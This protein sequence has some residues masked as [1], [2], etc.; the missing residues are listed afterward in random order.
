MN[1]IKRV[2]T[3]NRK[4][5]GGFRRLCILFVFLPFWALNAGGRTVRTAI[6]PPKPLPVHESEASFEIPDIPAELPS[7][8]A[9]SRA[10]TVFRSI[11]KAYPDRIGEIE[12][13]DGDWTIQ[14]YGEIFYY[15]EGRLLPASLRDRQ[16]EYSPQPFYNYQ[17]ELPPWQ[18]P[19]P[20][21][22]AR[23]KEQETL[24]QARPSKR[25]S[26]F[27]DA[28]WRTRNRDESWEHIKQIR[29]L[30]HTV[31]V[32]YSI[33]VDLSL[34]EE[35]ILR[36]AKTNT[37]VSRWIN[38]I[39]SV[40]AWNWRNIASS[41]SRS[42]HAYG[43]AIDILPKS[44][45]GLETYWLWTA[46]HTPE[47]WAVPYT[48]RFH[49]PDEVIAIFESFGFTWGGK[50]RYYDTMHFEYRPEILVLSGIER[51]DLKSLR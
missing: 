18:S 49:P 11:A 31:Q 19:T 8:Q 51:K 5:L 1:L 13:W 34:V 30:G 41:E 42:F 29:F 45:G 24:R 28:L 16:A 33:L 39:N 38:N 9:E 35:T 17:K 36:T 4:T 46:R 12:F 20:E 27:F 32:H 43:A 48:R 3:A 7:R 40:D 23:M 37:A 47:W 44:L 22:S 25:S 6:L 26:H 10:E 14:V 2:K 21:E 50:W 15:A